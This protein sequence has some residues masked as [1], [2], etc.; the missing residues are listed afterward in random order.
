MVESTAGDGLLHGFGILE[1]CTSV[2]VPETESSVRTNCRQ[3]S[4]YR[5]ELDVIHL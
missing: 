5:V 1:L 3:S 2:F 4:M